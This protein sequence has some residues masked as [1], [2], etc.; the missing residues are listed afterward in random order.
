MASRQT[1]HLLLVVTIIASL[2]QPALAQVNIT[3]SRCADPSAYTSCNADVDDADSACVAGC[4]GSWS[5]LAGCNCTTYQGY[6]NCMASACW[7]QVYSCEYQNLV[8]Q[9][10]NVC[11]SAREPIPFWPSPPN[12]SAACSCNLGR[13]SDYIRNITD[14]QVSCFSRVTS[15]TTAEGVEVTRRASGC[16]CCGASARYSAA[17]TLCPNIPLNPTNPDPDQSPD[18]VPS[19]DFGPWAQLDAFLDWTLNWAS[20]WAGSA[21]GWASDWDWASCENTLN[22]TDCHTDLGFTLPL[23]GGESSAFYGPADLPASSSSGAV[24]DPLSNGGGTVTA[25]PSGTVFVWSQASAT[26]TVTAS[27]YQSTGTGSSVATGAGAVQTTTTSAGDERRDGIVSL[28]V[29]F[30]GAVLGVML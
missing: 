22:S 27:G 19:P 30:V 25:P 23:G 1:L 10:L 15:S 24:V 17:R 26:Y 16:A 7:N 8:L 13:M 18:P 5:C 28:G 12:A 14:E 21:S 11:P 3:D 20:E 9:Y 2:F 4:N 29:A 6:I